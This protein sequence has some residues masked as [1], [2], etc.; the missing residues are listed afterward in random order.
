MAGKKQSL[1]FDKRGG[2]IVLRRQLIE[3]ENYQTL[4]TYARALMTLLQVQWRPDKPVDYGIREAGKRLVCNRKTAMK[5]FNQ[6]TERGFLVCVE[7]S[8]FSSRTQSK[9]RSWRLT[10]LPFDFEPPSNNWEKWKTIN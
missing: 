9:T 6:L 4:S 10:W 3:S 8:K 5:A 7:Q 2:T 1:P